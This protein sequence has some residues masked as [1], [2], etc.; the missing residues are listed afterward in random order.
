MSCP[1]DLPVPLNVLHHQ[2]P[3]LES[4]APGQPASSLPVANSTRP[5]WLHPSSE[6]NPLAREGSEGTLTADADICIIGSGITGV[7]A[8]YHISKYIKAN[9]DVG[10]L[11]VVVL[12]ARDFCSGA[13]EGRNGGHLTPKTYAHFRKDVDRYGLMEALKEVLVEERTVKEL[14]QIIR[15][16]SLEDTVDVVAEGRIEL[17]F[18]EEAMKK[19]LADYQAAKDAGADVDSVEWF[20]REEM[21]KSRGT[22]YPGVKIP[23]SNLW[24]LKLVTALYKLALND[25]SHEANACSLT[26]HTHTPVL[27]ISSN[28]SATT[29]GRH[30]SLN[31]PRGPISCGI[32]LHATNAYASHLLSHMWGPEGI[33][34]TR[35]QIIATRASASAETLGKE[36]W[37]GNQ[38]LE[39][40]FPRPVR[41]PKTD[42]NAERDK[43]LHPLVILGGGREVTSPK[44][45]LYEVDDSVVNKDIS[46]V[47][48]KFL[49][50]VFPGKFE[51]GV[52]P[53]WEWTGIMGFT[54]TGAPFVGPVLDPQSP[55]SASFIGQYIAAGYT[56]HGMPRAYACAEA[57]VGLIMH[58]LRGGK[59]Q[60]WSPPEWLP[61]HYLTWER[62]RR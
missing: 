42:H 62:T 41:N 20:S 61:K 35:G 16:N 32:V 31:T 17:M 58:E 60:D 25:T 46:D 37:T 27:S 50:A 48:R 49:P 28:T 40:W 12:E 11:K 9:Q 47:L 23:G 24:P 30:W 22:L 19:D 36:G 21:E 2:Q 45:E 10:N 39:Y 4:L 5:F 51:T 1:A 15:E 38:K 54:K 14:W 43:N 26:L 52:E 8:A 53:E 6:V 18:T 33:I 57:V 59:R 56:G 13:T 29:K 3:A 34:P 44:F 55:N 7:S